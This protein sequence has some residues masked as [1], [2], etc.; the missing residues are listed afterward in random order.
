MNS[1]RYQY[2][3]IYQ[4]LVII[5][6]AKE[7]G[8]KCMFVGLPWWLRWKRIGL[9][10]RRLWF[11]PW[12]RKIPW[13]REWQPSPVFL[14]KK[15]HRQ[16]RLAGYSPRGCKESDKTERLTTHFSLHMYIYVHTCIFHTIDRLIYF[17]ICIIF[18]YALYIINII[19]IHTHRKK[20]RGES[21]E[22]NGQM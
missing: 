5:L 3:E 10:C 20:M 17:H 13:R 18:R 12:V 21:E 8:M 15:F 2:E 19:Y 11:K 1:R 7:C 16:K 9:Q 14:P 6:N 4:F 22:E